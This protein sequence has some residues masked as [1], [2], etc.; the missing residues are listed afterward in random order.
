MFGD[1]G[2]SYTNGTNF[3]YSPGTYGRVDTGASGPLQQAVAEMMRSWNPT[4]VV[5]LGDEVRVEVVG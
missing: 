4:D 2:N 5:Q 1:A 3:Y